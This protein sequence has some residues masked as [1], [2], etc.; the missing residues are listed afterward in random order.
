MDETIPPYPPSE[1]WQWQ[2]NSTTL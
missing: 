2:R 1:C